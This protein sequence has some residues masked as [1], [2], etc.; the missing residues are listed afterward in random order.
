MQGGGVQ[1]VQLVLLLLLVF[2]AVFGA[3]ARRLQTPYPIVLLVAGLALSFIPG[4]PQVTLDPELVFFVLLPPLL[5]AG[6]WTTSWRDFSYNLVSIV[7]LAVGLVAFTVLGVAFTARWWRL[8]TPSPRPASPSGS[9]FRG[10]SWTFSGGR[11][12]STTPR[13]SW[14]SSSAS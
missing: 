6:A 13:A 8:P 7:S 3:V 5:Y 4:I 11:A 14:R 1:P 9:G 2:V 10:A 12:W